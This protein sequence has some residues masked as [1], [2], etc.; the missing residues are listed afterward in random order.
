MKE[1]AKVHRA[2]SQSEKHSQTYK[3]YKYTKALEIQRLDMETV[4]G[5]R[6]EENGDSGD[7]VQIKV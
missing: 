2:L 5:K 6:R 3:T 7:Y 4:I 1:R